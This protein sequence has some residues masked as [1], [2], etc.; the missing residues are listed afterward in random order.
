M[1]PAVLVSGSGRILRGAD[2]VEN[3]LRNAERLEAGANAA[4]T[5][6]A[7][8]GPETA[9]N[10]FSPAP[11]MLRPQSAAGA[12]PQGVAARE[13][14]SSFLR[15]AERLEAQFSSPAPHAI[16]RGDTRGGMHGDTDGEMLGDMHGELYGGCMGPHVGTCAVTLG[17]AW[18][19]YKGSFKTT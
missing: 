16:M 13:D 11:A 18:V 10:V 8:G 1:G 5:A 17:G 12:P 19:A 3:F 7:E 2:D 15:N 4:A 9:S 6:A 14:L